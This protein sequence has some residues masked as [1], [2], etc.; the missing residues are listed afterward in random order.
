MAFAVMVF[1]VPVPQGKRFTTNVFGA[2]PTL[3]IHA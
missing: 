3:V 2:T 1:P